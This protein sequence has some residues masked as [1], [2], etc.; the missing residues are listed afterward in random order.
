[1]C[2]QQPKRLRAVPFRNALLFRNLLQHC[3]PPSKFCGKLL[4]QSGKGCI[5]CSQ[6]TNMLFRDI[7]ITEHTLTPAFE[8]PHIHTFAQR[9]LQ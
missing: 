3:F 5:I 7:Q 6:H 4:P 8:K 2:L 9:R 1:M